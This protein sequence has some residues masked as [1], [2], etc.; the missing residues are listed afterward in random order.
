MSDQGNCGSCSVASCAAE[1]ALDL[2]AVAR[3]MA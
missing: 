2:Q 1:A 3:R